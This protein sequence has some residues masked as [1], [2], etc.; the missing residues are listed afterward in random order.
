MSSFRRACACMLLA[1][2]VACSPDI[3]P[4]VVTM[5][6]GV[7]EASATSGPDPLTPLVPLD[8][9]TYEHSGQ[10]VHPDVVR[11]AVA[12]QGWEYWMAMTPFPKGKEAFE[13][14]SIL[15]SHDGLRWQVPTGLSNPLAQTPERKGYNSDPDLSYDAVNDRLVLIYR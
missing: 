3:P 8:I 10:A 14:P 5:P 15:V 6:A 13:N 12:W 9:P 4:A 2:V 1:I 11:F 7:P